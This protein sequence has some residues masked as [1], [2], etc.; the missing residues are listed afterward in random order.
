[1]KFKIPAENYE[2]LEKKIVSLN[3]K[4]QKLNLEPIEL[5]II[6][7]IGVL[8]PKKDGSFKEIKY[9]NVNVTGEPPVLD[10]WKLVGIIEPTEKGNF[11]TEINDSFSIP[12]KYRHTDLCDC[13]HCGVKRDRTA[14]FVVMNKESLEFLQVGRVCLKSY[15]GDTDPKNIALYE[16]FFKLRDFSKHSNE[17]NLKEMFNVD[18]ILSLY[19]KG[20][21]LYPDM[22][23][24]YLVNVIINRNNYTSNIYREEIN[25]I[26]MNIL[27]NIT[28]ETFNKVK[29]FKESILSLKNENNNSLWN[30][31]LALKD[32]Y[33]YKPFM[34]TESFEFKK[35]YDE[36]MTLKEKLLKE[37][38]L[39]AQLIFEEKELKK[40]RVHVGV[41]GEKNK[42]KVTIEKIVPSYSEWGTSFVYTFR[43]E[44]KNCIVWFNSGKALFDEDTSQ[45]YIKNNKTFYI[46]GTVKKLS[47]YN[48]EPQT[49]L[50]RVKNL[51][52]QLENKVKVKKIKPV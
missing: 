5:D 22:K 44:N 12:V 14:A 18:N 11:I 3:N 39:K 52:N 28:D 29:E 34:L 47:Q 20:K 2:S 16:S 19:I 27:E 41:E 25:N 15:T 7:S 17:P 51:G 1:M 37:A 48:D 9:L 46:E 13:E 36:N 45:D 8:I 31:Q 50:I 23:H 42:Y 24:D 43:D 26:R 40:T 49:Q 6:S 30:Y 33:T 32:K 10:G 35:A 38:I 4:A 21:E